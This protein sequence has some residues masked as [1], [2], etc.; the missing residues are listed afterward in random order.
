[1]TEKEK[2]RPSLSSF[3]SELYAPWLTTMKHMI[4]SSLD[5][6]EKLTKEALDRYADAMSWA[7]DTP[8]APVYKAFIAAARKMLETST[9]MVRA[10]WQLDKAKDGPEEMQNV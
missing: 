3:S 8:W 1:M 10:L 2:H 9:I 7:K 6:N 4:A 5:T